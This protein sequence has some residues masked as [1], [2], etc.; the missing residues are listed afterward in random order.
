ML[1]LSVSSSSVPPAN[2]LAAAAA[3]P[4]AAGA[5][6]LFSVCSNG[7]IEEKEKKSL[8]RF[9]VLICCF[10]GFKLRSK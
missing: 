4:A 2:E 9:R 6:F 10:R 3:A 7:K 1:L 5:S 8:R